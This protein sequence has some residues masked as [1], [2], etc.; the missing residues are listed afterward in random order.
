[1][2]TVNILSNSSACGASLKKIVLRNNLKITGR[3]V[4]SS[5]NRAAKISE[6]DIADSSS[7]VSS[8]MCADSSAFSRLRIHF[9]SGGSLSSGNRDADDAARDSGE[10]GDLPVRFLC[11]TSLAPCLMRLF[12]PQEF[13]L[14]RL[15]GTAKT[16]RFC[17][18]TMRA[19]IRAL[20]YSAARTAS[21]RTVIT[22]GESCPGHSS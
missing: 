16:S 20:E 2:S 1:M 10:A 6:D 13:L 17:S 11:S 7:S 3:S 15:P 9:S 22:G 12:R 8:P 21:G 18:S 19:V 14:V 4:S 5:S